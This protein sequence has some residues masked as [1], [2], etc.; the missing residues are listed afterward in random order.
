MYSVEDCKEATSVYFYLARKCSKNRKQNGQNNMYSCLMSA[1][2]L[3][4]LSDDDR[5]DLH[6]SPG[7]RQP[8]RGKCPLY[9][10]VHVR[11]RRYLIA[12]WV[13]CYFLFTHYYRSK[14]NLR[15]RSLARMV[16]LLARS[17]DLARP[18]VARPLWATELIWMNQNLQNTTVGRQ[19]D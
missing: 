16:D 4:T 5:R 15:A 8:R 17:F 6:H 10:V 12:W 1:N 11:C 18:G 2:Y 14:A 9:F 7:Q 13:S 3:H 19:T